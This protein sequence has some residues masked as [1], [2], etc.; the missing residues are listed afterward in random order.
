HQIHRARR[1]QR[2]Q[3][4]VDGRPR[5]SRRGWQNRP[6]LRHAHP[7]RCRARNAH[8]AVGEQ[9]ARRTAQEGCGLGARHPHLRS[10]GT[11]RRR[12]RTEPLQHEET[13]H[14]RCGRGPVDHRRH[15]C[16]ERRRR[17]R[18]RRA[19]NLRPACRKPGQQHRDLALRRAKYIGGQMPNS[20]KSTLLASVAALL[21]GSA[22]VTATNAADFNIPGGDLK[23]ALDSYS[24]QTGVSLLYSDQAIKGARSR[25]VQGDIAPDEALSRILSGTGFQ[26]RRHEGS[27]ITIV[28]GDTQAVEEIGN[29]QIAQAAPSSRAA[30]E[31]VTV[32]S[33]KLGGADVQSIPIAITALSQEQLTATQTAGGPD[34]VKQVPNLTFTKTNFTG[35]SIQIRGIG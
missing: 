12:A 20:F 8:L 31:T 33:S 21:A 22:F 9:E 26:I 10:P 14:R 2:H 1:R 18:Q 5:A 11:L 3:S 35:Y 13:R 27:A 19:R 7:R 30:V 25:G 23:A 29:L 4:R 24:R 6:A 17:H 16:N 32:T 15:V 28:R 34:L